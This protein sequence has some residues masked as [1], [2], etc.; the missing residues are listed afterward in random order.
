MSERMYIQEIQK[1][2]QYRVRKSVRRWCCNNNV[3]ILSDVGSNKQYVLRDEYEKAKNK[4][5]NTNTK[6]INSSMNFFS[7]NSNAEKTKEYRPQ[8]EQEIKF[9]NCLQNF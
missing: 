9:L 8:G 3:R 2:L 7:M 1:E 4:N 5:Y 6:V